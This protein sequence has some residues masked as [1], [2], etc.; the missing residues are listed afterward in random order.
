[1]EW[2]SWPRQ[3]WEASC[4]CIEMWEGVLSAGLSLQFW[5]GW[6]TCLIRI[7]TNSLTRRG[8]REVGRVPSV[9]RV[10]LANN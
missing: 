8:A 2:T 4:A 1:M 3:G 6:V 5:N 7:V 10:G 9:G